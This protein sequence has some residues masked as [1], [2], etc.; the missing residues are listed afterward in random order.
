MFRGVIG[1]GL[2]K[3]PGF[4]LDI[5]LQKVVVGSDDIQQGT[6]HAAVLVKEIIALGHR[7]SENRTPSLISFGW[8]RPGP[9]G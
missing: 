1:A 5:I 3:V 9:P 6:D 4:G 7:L 8:G 2:G